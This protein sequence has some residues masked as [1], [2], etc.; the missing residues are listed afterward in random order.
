MAKLTVTLVGGLAAIGVWILVGAPGEGAS[1][2]RAGPSLPGGLG[3]N[4]S[5][6]TD[7]LSPPR[8]MRFDDIFVGALGTGNKGGAGAV[9]SVGTPAPTGLV[10]NLTVVS[11]GPALHGSAAQGTGRGKPFASDEA[12]DARLSPAAPAGCTSA[13]GVTVRQQPNRWLGTCFARLA[14]PPKAI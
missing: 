5:A 6:K 8:A 9:A 2:G 7:R 13:F 1:L 10:S 14:A 4:R 11:I 3:I 12:P